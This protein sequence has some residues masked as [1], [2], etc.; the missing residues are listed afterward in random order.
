MLALALLAAAAAHPVELLRPGLF[1]KGEIAVEAGSEWLGLAPAA[2]PSGYAWRP[3]AIDVE[4]AMDPLVDQ[5]SER[6]GSE[7]KVAGPPPLILLRGLDR[8]RDVKV[9]TAFA[10]A[11]GQ[12]LTPAAALD[13]RLGAAHYRLT[14]AP[15]GASAILQ[16]PAAR[17]VVRQIPRGGRC[18]VLW[19]GDLDGDG[20]LDILLHFIDNPARRDLIL[21]LSSG[22]GKGSLVEPVARLR[23]AE[24]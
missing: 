12:T 21:F 16:S 23:T 11:K 6:T 7:V 20:R 1:H 24:W 18:D 22:A 5:D 17:Q 15:D 13:L 10:S 2:L 8:L 3:Y 4:P 19:A 9:E 14:L